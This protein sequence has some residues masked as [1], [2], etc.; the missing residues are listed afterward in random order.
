MSVS[1]SRFFLDTNILAHSFDDRDPVRKEKAVELT[2]MALTTGLGIIS[3]QVVQEFLN[4]SVTKFPSPLSTEDRR[5]Y[6]DGV[7]LPL[8]QVWPGRDLYLRALDVQSTSGYAFYDSL[9]VAAALRAGCRT[10]YTQDLQRGRRFDVLT[11][12]DPFV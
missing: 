10:L 2:E 9:I 5:D 3:Y 6:L 1:P 7:L 8:C 4:V 11:V 12:V